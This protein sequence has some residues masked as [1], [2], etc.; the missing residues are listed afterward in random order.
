MLEN[1]PANLQPWRTKIQKQGDVQS[2]GTQVIDHLS[3]MLGSEAAHCLDLDEKAARNNDIGNECANDDTLV[4]NLKDSL[5]LE[6]YPLSD[7]LH[8]QRVLID[9]LQ[10]ACS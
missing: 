3:L 4:P 5:S 2:S 10:E 7:K 1:Q 9:R 6:V 8:A